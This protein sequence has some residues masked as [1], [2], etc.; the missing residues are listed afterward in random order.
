MTIQDL[1]NKLSTIITEIESLSIDSITSETLAITRNKFIGQKSDISSLYKE[2]SSLPNADKP[3]AGK[4]INEAKVKVESFF[5]ALDRQLLEREVLKEDISDIDVTAPFNADPSE[6][7]TLPAVGNLHPLSEELEKILTIFEKMG[8]HVF[9]GRDLD[10]EYF[11]FDSLGFPK[12]HPARENWDAFKTEDGLMPTPHTSNMQVRIMRHFKKPPI[13]S[14]IYGRCFRNE[15]VDAVHAHTFYQI[16]GVYIDKGITV[17]NMIG[18]IKAYI[19]AFFE[20]EIVWRIQPAYFPFVEPGIEFMIRCVFCG[21]KGCQSCKY[22]G[23][24]EVAGAGMIHPVV[25]RE[26]GIDPK[27]YSGFA[28]GLGLDRMVMQKNKIKDIR[29][30]FGSDIRFLQKKHEILP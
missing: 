23:W 7:T 10:S 29:S 3:V 30:L 4:L 18:T 24:L 19:E 9:E 16:E 11:I 17:A 25:L 1:E 27:E 8:F 2:L 5:D 20:Q 22:G 12:N 21:G 13:R 26:G 28:W 15:A 14:V 6:I